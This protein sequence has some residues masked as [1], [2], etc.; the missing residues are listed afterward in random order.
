MTVEEFWDKFMNNDIL[1][2]FEDACELFSTELPDYFIEEYD[3]EEILLEVLGHQETE[4]NFDNILKFTDIIKD[5]QPE[6]YQDLF[7][8][9][10]DFLIEYY[11]FKQDVEQVKNAFENF[12]KKPLQDFDAYL[13]QLN[14][15]LFYQ[16]TEILEQAVNEESYRLVQNSDELMDG[17]EFDLAFIKM[18]TLLQNVYESKGKA[19]DIAS[20]ISSMEDYDS[21]FKS[22]FASSLE[23][24][25]FKPVLDAD[26][27]NDLFKKDKERA[28]TVIHSSFFCYMHSKD[29]QFYVSAKIIDRLQSYWD[30]RNKK[31]NTTNAFF[32]VETTSFDEFI[33]SFSGGMFSSNESESI[34][35]LW[36]SVH[37]YEFLYKHN[38]IS[39]ETF[40]SFLESSKV[41]KGRIIA[42]YMT[43][44]WK[45][46]F[47]HIWPKPDCVSEVEFIQERNIFKKSIGLKY[48]PFGE[49]R[50][51]IS[52]EL[53]EIGELAY[54][55]NEGSNY[56]SQ[57][58]MSLLDSMFN[59]NFQE[60]QYVNEDPDIPYVREEKK[61]GRNE[62]CP[63]G[64]GKKYKKCCG[65]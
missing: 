52:D 7:Q 39:Q 58:N 31:A 28:F 24:G 48:K 43:D 38:Y 14:R 50:G 35:V 30:E 45:S 27:I 25:L 60:V 12:N 42:R 21:E 33:N 3:V 16:H 32:A 53:A 6:L 51:E 23:T 57:S 44:L 10:D 40:E 59:Q 63:C 65:K 4:K 13:T 64:S 41:I 55:I 15:V 2:I 20:F 34:A 54:H 62:P 19:P 49:L 8:Y 29:I 11:C 47:V 22:G 56:Q 61:V 9:F 37:F 17:A 18:Y 46:D 5:K 36:G 26:S 1:E